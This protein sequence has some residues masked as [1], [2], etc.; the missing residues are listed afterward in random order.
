MSND[1]SELR[2]KLLAKRA[3]Q[4]RALEEAKN[5]VEEFKK[6]QSS[7]TEEQIS[8]LEKYG[9]DVRFLQNVQSDRL[10]TDTNYLA[11]VKEQVITV[12]STLQQEVERVL[13]TN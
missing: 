2:D 3:L 4:A 7:L 1:L 5:S 8:A 13:C 9:I 6:I 12:V 10:L 11:S